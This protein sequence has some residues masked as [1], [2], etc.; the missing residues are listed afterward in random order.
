MGRRDPSAFD[1]A[2]PPIVAVGNDYPPSFEVVR[3]QHRRGQLLY[4]ARGVIVVRTPKGAWI[5]PPERA[6]WT[7]PGCPHSVRMMGEVSTLGL[8][9]EPESVGALGDACRVLQVTP[10]V[11]SLLVEA[12]SIGSVYD[13]DGRD[14]LLMALLLAELQGAPEVPLAVPFPASPRLARRCQVF[15][16]AP[17]HDQTIDDWCSDLGLGR[18]TFTR[19]FRRETGL[20]FGAWRQQV[21]LL[22]AIPRLA[23]G[24]PVTSIALDLGYE[25][26][27]AFTTM[28][29]RL[30]GT[31]PSRYGKSERPP[32]ELC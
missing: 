15:L 5:A 20:S 19:W 4:A 21:C 16:E 12:R 8:M 10:L 27:A 29:K 30:T 2:A 25:S 22:I 23:A 6:I 31:P 11:R 18:R 3:H 9:I 17:S 26:V 32:E 7:P 24:D 1:D 28:F 13:A 14:G